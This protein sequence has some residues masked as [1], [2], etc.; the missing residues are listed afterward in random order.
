MEVE[1]EMEV[2][3]EV[4]VEMEVKERTGNAKETLT[5]RRP[6][7]SFLLILPPLILRPPPLINLPDLCIRPTSRGVT[8]SASRGRNSHRSPRT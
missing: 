6:V 2:K 5:R 4:E 3:M 7:L 1:V 8:P